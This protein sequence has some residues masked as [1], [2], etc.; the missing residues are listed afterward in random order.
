MRYSKF[1]IKKYKGIE[2]LVLDL[3]SIPVLNIFTLVGLNESGKTTILEAINSFQN[4]AKDNNEL[5]PKSKR[6]NFNDSITI[7]AHLKA[8]S[9]DII[10]INDF[11][12]SQGYRLAK[13]ITEFTVE[14]VLKY[15]SSS[16]QKSN[17]IWQM[18]LFVLPINS[19]SKKA[20]DL[21]KTNEPVWQKLIDYIRANLLPKIV[22]YPN[23][24]FNFPNAIYLEEREGEP[25]EARFY[26]N[27]VQ[28]VLNSL[29]QDLNIKTH[30]VDRKVNGTKN[31]LENIEK[32]LSDMAGMIT[33]SVFTAWGRISGIKTSGFSVVLGNDIKI[34]LEGRQYIEMKIKEGTDSYYIRERSLGFR[35][36]FAFLLFTLFRKHRGG[37][38]DNTLFLL[39]E[40]ASNLHQTGQKELLG[41]FEQ[42]TEGS[43]VIYSTHSHHLINPKWLSGTFI[44]KNKGLDPSGKN[45]NDFNATK[46]D[47]DAE[48]YFSFVSHNPNE[49]THFKPILDV[50]EYA[51]SALESVPNI[52][53]TEGK[54]DFYTFLY[55]KE[56]ILKY[57]PKL[58]LYPGAGRDK[59]DRIIALYLAWGK[60]FIV[61][62]DGDN[63]GLKSQVKYKKDFGTIVDNK[64]FTLADIDANFN[65]ATEELFTNEELLGVIQKVFPK[66]TSYNKS[67]FNS[68]LQQLYINNE[69]FV[70]SNETKAK[71]EKIL[72]F[73]SK[74]ISDL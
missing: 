32:V 53:I 17:A 31:D 22:Y 73:M 49:E 63:P 61:L 14:N 1:E 46:T 2:K 35:W 45:L 55:F 16:Y 9:E 62:L 51:P 29:N 11:L 70:F 74:R 52:V 66:E 47:I 72:D 50:L 68:A 58:Y 34:D 43:M 18:G 54:F 65:L 60:P 30:L 41:S 26:R 6:S 40:P 27:V 44:V 3:D 42:L 56:I 71:I 7:K 25:E 23:F 28:D 21:Y 4:P 69:V 67:M 36:F 13:D 39:D 59:H 8:D 38:V 15:L 5:I 20:L 12:K 19:K 64:I 48:R 37:E 24:L 33:Q 10:A 57:K